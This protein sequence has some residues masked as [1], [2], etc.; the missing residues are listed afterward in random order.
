MVRLDEELVRQGLAPSADA[1]C[2]M[3]L[4]GEVSGVS[5]RYRSPGQRV[6]EG[7]PLHVRASKPYVSRGGLK[8]E[9]ALAA[10]HLDVTGFTCVDIGASTG[11]FTDCLLKAGAARVSAVDVAYGQFAWA[12][13]DDPRI[14][15]LERTNARALA[16]DPSRKGAYDLVVMD[17]SFA[18]AS[19]FAGLVAY[20]LAPGGFLLCL[21]KPQFEAAPEEVGEG[22]I[23]R[24]EG[25]RAEAVRHASAAFAEHGLNVEEVVPSP[26]KGAKGNQEYLLLARRCA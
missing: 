9:G 16:R 23:V 6:Q 14:E 10:F 20:L 24:E 26:V 4:A 18:S 15:L 17:V 8:L 2:R 5:E 21:V 7:A 25:V 12:L 3:I 1:A 11:G 22:G 19:S 13:R